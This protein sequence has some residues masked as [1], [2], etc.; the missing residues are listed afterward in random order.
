[1]NNL[2]DILRELK[3]RKNPQVGPVLR[4][5]K[6]DEIIIKH[7]NKETRFLDSI[8]KNISIQQRFYHVWFNI[9]NPP[10][11]EYC[12]DVKKFSQYSRFSIDQNKKDS[13]YYKYCGGIKCITK[14]FIERGCGN[15]GY[16]ALIAKIKND[17]KLYED[18][19]S[20]TKFLDVFYDDI[21]NSQR[22][23]HIFFESY[24]IEKCEF[25]GTPKKFT[26][27]DK[28]STNKNK[29]D[30]NYCKSCNSKECI[31]LATIKESKK[32]VFNKYGVTNIWEIPGYRE[33]LTNT[34]LIKYGSEYIMGSEHFKDKVKETINIKW[35][36]DH[37]TKHEKTKNKKYE[38]N[39]K[40]YGF[41]CALQNSQI[42]EKQLKSCFKSKKYKMTS[43]KIVYVQGYEPWAL[44][45]LLAKYQENDI[46]VDKTGIEKYIGKTKYINENNKTCIYFPDIYIK[47]INEIIE[48]KSEY[49]YLINE[50]ENILKKNAILN[51]GIKFSF[52][53]FDINKNLRII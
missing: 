37:P 1:M 7:I 40:K 23:Y 22:F 21:S 53:I 27:N 50:N 39:L 45:I 33:K 5:I 3:S 46:I 47:S 18:L 48:V 16:G 52:W 36:G 6:R 30:S 28:F 19:C 51:K 31:L 43:G 24:E 20:E 35:G 14:D 2:Y 41:S 32:G 44:D 4:K 26:F 17:P 49:T 9:T 8:Y 34:N 10:K 42:Q 25:C 38:T 13:N 29:R 12:E 11:C 15:Q